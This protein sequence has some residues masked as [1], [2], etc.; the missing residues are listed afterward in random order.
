MA[1]DKS[2]RKLRSGFAA[3][4]RDLKCHHRDCADR[5]VHALLV[6]TR[7]KGYVDTRQGVFICGPDAVDDLVARLDRDKQTAIPVEKFLKEEAYRPLPT[8]L[9]AA[10]EL[11]T[12]NT[13][14]RVHKAA[15]A[16]EPTAARIRDIATE[17]ARTKSRKLILLTGVPGAGRRLSDYTPCTGTG[18]MNWRLTAVPKRPLPQGCF[19]PATAPLVGKAGQ[20]SNVLRDLGRTR[21]LDSPSWGAQNRVPDLSRAATKPKCRR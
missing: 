4:A 12:T 1:V 7:A 3:Y 5:P 18:S 21:E 10:R 11:F 19:C 2:R 6:P 16:T 13:L 20:F 15:A 9:A 14:S 8:L 17:A